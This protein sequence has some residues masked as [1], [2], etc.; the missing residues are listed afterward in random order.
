LSLACLAVGIAGLSLAVVL[1]AVRAAGSPTAGASPTLVL[2]KSLLEGSV[3]SLTPAQARRAV[4]VARRD[5]YVRELVKD[6]PNELDVE[7]AWT[8]SDGEFLG[9]ALALIF[10]RPTLVTGTWL[11]LV[12]DCSERSM[13]PYKTSTYFASRANVSSL[14]ILVDL[15]RLRV[16]AVNPDAGARLIARSPH[17]AFSHAPTCQPPYS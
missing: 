10:R 1:V 3:P 15:E 5:H 9:A 17:L 4:N 12:Y 14:T 16:V 8:K 13:T 6:H 11:D 7:A 2:G